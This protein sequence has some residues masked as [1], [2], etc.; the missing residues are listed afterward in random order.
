MAV[1]FLLNRFKALLVL[2][3]GIFKRAM[4]CLRR[5]RR[6]SCDCEPLS[7]VGVVPNVLTNSTVCLKLSLFIEYHFFYLISFIIINYKYVKNCRNLFMQFIFMQLCKY[8]LL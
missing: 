6:S 2:L 3:F 1:E 5:R 4:C 8:I 7:T